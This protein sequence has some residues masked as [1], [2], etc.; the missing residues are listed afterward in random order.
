MLVA[1][2]EFAGIRFGPM[3]A[4]AGCRI[5]AVRR[6]R[7]RRPRPGLGRRRLR[8]AGWDEL[9]RDGP[10]D[11]DPVPE[12]L[13]VAF[14]TSGT[15]GLPEAR[16]ARPGEVGAPQPRHRPGLR[17]PARRSAAAR[18][19]VVRH[20]RVHAAAGGD[21]GSG[22]DAHRRALRS[23]RLGA[24]DRGGGRHALQRQ[25]RHAAAHPGDRRRAFGRSR[26]A[27]GR[28]RQLHER[29]AAGGDGHRRPRRVRQRALRQLGGLR[30]PDPLASDDDGRR[31]RPLRRGAHQ[32]GDGARRRRSRHRLHPRDRRGGRA[33]PARPDDHAPLPR[34]PGGDGEGDGRR[35]LVPHR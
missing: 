14:T 30:P 23:R 34:R 28:V 3:A 8:R 1:V 11:H 26:P 10:V 12:D 21:R 17:H 24:G 9:H 6:R 31:A 33:A 5:A 29:R 32:P 27:R 22:P 18:R 13:L 15:T 19:A 16:R 25:R 4:D 35:R 20:V 2:D 7:R